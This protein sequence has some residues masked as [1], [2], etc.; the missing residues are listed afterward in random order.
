MINNPENVQIDD[1]VKLEKGS[2]HYEKWN[3]YTFRVIAHKFID[4]IKRARAV[5]NFKNE[6]MGSTNHYIDE[7]YKNLIIIRKN[8]KHQALKKEVDDIQ[9]VEF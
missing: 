8:P 2:K 3:E 6:K 9:D 1:I 7:P 4:G 5:R